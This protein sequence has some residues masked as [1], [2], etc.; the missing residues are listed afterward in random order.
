MSYEEM[1]TRPIRRSWQHDTIIESG[2]KFSSVPLASV[3]R[4]FLQLENTRQV[5]DLPSVYRIISHIIRCH[6]KWDQAEI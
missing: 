3:G 5:S 2:R 4:E 1:T 6:S